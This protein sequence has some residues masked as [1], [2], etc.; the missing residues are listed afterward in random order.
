M[1]ECEKEYARTHN[2]STEG[3]Y[4]LPS[5]TGAAKTGAAVGMYGAGWAMSVAMFAATVLLL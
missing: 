3:M 5:E 2:G 4:A 1:G